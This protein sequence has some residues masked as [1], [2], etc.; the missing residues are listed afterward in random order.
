MGVGYGIVEY[1]WRES[2]LQGRALAAVGVQKK[3]Q[4]TD[5]IQ[6]K[7]KVNT[8]ATLITVQI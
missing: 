2:D 5:K 1:K 4:F 7:D 6:R 8:E 3:E